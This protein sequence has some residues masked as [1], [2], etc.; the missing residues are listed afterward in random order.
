MPLWVQP[1]LRA[2]QVAMENEGLIQTRDSV[3]ITIQK[4]KE[5]QGLVAK[6]GV[7]GAFQVLRGNKHTANSEL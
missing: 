5:S 2:R 6:P 1:A 3:A 7:A 4:A